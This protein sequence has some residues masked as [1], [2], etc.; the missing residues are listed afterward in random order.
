MADLFRMAWSYLR[1]RLLLSSTLVLVAA[2]SI[3]LPVVT[4]Q[5]VSQYEKQLAARSE[6]PPL[7]VGGRGSRYGLVLKTLYFLG[8]IDRQ[9]TYAA[10]QDLAEASNLVSVPLHVVHTARRHTLPVIGTTDEYFT[11][12]NIPVATGQLFSQIGHC[13]V[14]SHVGNVGDR[15]KTDRLNPFDLNAPPSVALEVV[16]VLA[17]TY[18]PDDDGVFVSLETAWLLDG[19]GH[20]HQA[21]DTGTAVDKSSVLADSTDGHLPAEPVTVIDD[22]NRGQIHFHGRRR[23][24]KLSAVAVWPQTAKAGVLAEGRYLDHP[25]LQMLVPGAEFQ[26][27]I[28]Y[29]LGIKSVLDG[30]FVVMLVLTGVLMIVI[31]I[32]TVHLRR[33]HLHTMKMLGCAKS[34]VVLV[35]GV[36]CGL[37][38]CGALV[39]AAGMSLVLILLSP[40]LVT[41]F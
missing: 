31:A 15:I 17:P 29:V 23:Q 40:A 25:V 8:D 9:I 30:V 18:S 21:G 2:V 32:Q 10:Y 39:V 6:N 27:L 37:L 33:E 12:R 20:G 34:R 7:L 16:G 5:V 1:S 35:L 41:W 11:T 36:E 24:Y 26:K 3:S 19:Y 22:S 38:L 14:G 4:S 28:D 13:V